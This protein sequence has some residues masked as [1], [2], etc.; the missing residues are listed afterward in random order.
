MDSNRTAEL[1]RQIVQIRTG[2]LPPYCFDEA[3]AERGI[4]DYLSF[5]AARGEEALVAA[6]AFRQA[7]ERFER[8]PHSSPA[9]DELL[10]ARRTLIA[11]FP[12]CRDELPAGADA[13][14]EMM[15]QGYRQ[16]DSMF[17]WLWSYLQYEQVLAELL[18]LLHT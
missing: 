10:E 17:W 12:F 15:L 1:V 7:L 16:P 2:L 3:G 18:P 14:T 9:I 4:E 11:H 8:S 13:H 6:V 5:Y